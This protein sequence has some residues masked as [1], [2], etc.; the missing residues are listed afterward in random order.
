[1][2][3]PLRDWAIEGLL[4]IVVDIETGADVTSMLLA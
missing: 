4:L 1:M 3:E 2:A